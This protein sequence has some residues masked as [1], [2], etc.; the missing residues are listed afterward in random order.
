MNRIQR[1]FLNAGIAGI[2]QVL[3]VG[4]VL[5]FALR[6][7][8]GTGLWVL[9]IPSLIVS[10]AF[11]YMFRRQLVLHFRVTKIAMNVVAACAL[12][13][14]VVL[15]RPESEP[16]ALRVMLCCFI[17]LYVGLYFWLLSDP[18]IGRE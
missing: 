13:L 10:F 16:P 15:G 7:D 4:I 5:Y 9:T 8:V 2:I 14:L 17:G 6:K 12:I 11:G 3:L 1:F 18:L